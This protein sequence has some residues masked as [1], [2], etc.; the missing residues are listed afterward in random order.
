MVIGM[1]L[2]GSKKPETSESDF[3]LEA[4]KNSQA[5]IEF[6]PDGTI[7]TANT[8]F[9]SVVGYQLG[10]VQGR[11]HSI[12]VDSDYAGSNEYRS[13]W[14]DL[15]N[16]RAHTDNFKR[17]GKHDKEV[18]IRA[19]YTPVKNDAGKV[20]K[21][22]KFATDITEEKLQEVK[23]K[24]TANLANALTVCQ[25]NVMMADNDL[26]IIFVNEQVQSMLRNREA[27]IRSVLPNFSVDNLVGTCVDDFHA[28]PA[29]QRTMLAKL[30][31]PYKTNLKLAS[32]TFRLI[33]TPWYD[34]EGTRVGTIVEWEDITEEL[35][36]QREEQLIMASNSR[37]KSALDVCQANV[38]MA[39]DKFDIVY[40]NESVQEM[41][42]KNESQLQT[43]LPKFN[44]DDLVGQNIDV[45]HKDPSHQRRM[46]E[47]LTD[48]YETQL[49]L[50]GLNFNLI[51]T[52]VFDSSHK[53]LGT[54]VEWEDITDKLAKHEQEKL[55]SAE[56]SRIKQ[57]LDSVS[58][59]AMVA[60]ADNII[61]YMNPAA[62]E[63]MAKAEADLRRDL[64]NFD[65]KN[66]VGQSVD[67]FHVNPAHQ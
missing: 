38:M 14:T 39:D 49:S 28:N 10:E 55:V 3:I 12:F 27:E 50:A 15:A 25:A 30:N 24:Q 61:V 5:V 60:D 62:N 36:K 11:H 67:V 9:L 41:L 44:A 13:F 47:A 35:A 33:A 65:S 21:V 46:L 52:P 8:N 2:F 59:S 34:T 42:K 48:V 58:T 18:W 54:I 57:A 31:Q 66:I 22:V 1:G 37:I 45:F 6:E 63:M 56:N 29:H 53:R 7:I 64:P 32:L 16:G 23:A 40:I 17:V 4:L 43:V 20:I 26:N 51:A 19:T